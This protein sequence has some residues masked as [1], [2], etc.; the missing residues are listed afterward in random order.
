MNKLPR[1]KKYVASAAV[2]ACAALGLHFNAASLSAGDAIFTLKSDDEGALT[3]DIVYDHNKCPTEGPTAMYITGNV[4]NTSGGS[5]SNMTVQMT[6]LTAGFTFGGG[7][8]DTI[9]LGTMAAGDTQMVGWLI[10]YPC[11]DGFTGTADIVIADIDPGTVQSTVD[12]TVREAK[13]ANA[14][15]NVITSVLGPGAVVGQII[16]MDTTYDFGNIGAGNEF[17]LQPA[18]SAAFDAGCFQ[19]MGA[20]VIASNINAIPVG[21]IDDM[22]FVASAKQTGNNFNTTVRWYFRYFICAQVCQL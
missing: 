2:L 21:A 8:A 22:H 16:E 10:E 4:T 11:T 12:F 19:I 7:Q 13:S 20:E 17:F 14:G 15:G 18:G 3:Q 6:N 9:Q 5:I 1:L